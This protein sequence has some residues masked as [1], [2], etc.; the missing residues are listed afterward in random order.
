MGIHIITDSGSDILQGE[1][2]DITVLPM[3]ITFGEK[4]YLDGVNLSHQQ[5]YELLIEEEQL[6]VTSQVTP[7]QFE[8]AFRERVEAGDTVIAVV[9]SG[10]LSGTW[11]SACIAAREFP[12]KVYVVDSESAAI[13]ER[14]L[15]ERAVQLI[16]EGAQVEE[17]VE[18]LET[19]KKKIRLVALLDTLEY[20]KRGGRI[21]KSAA[22]VGGILSIK[23]VVAVENGEVCLLGKARGSRN[24]NNLLIQEIQ[25]TAG[26][27]FDRPYSLG[28]TGITDSLLQKY[29]ADSSV[30]WEEHADSLPIFS[31]GGTIGTHVG[32][33][34]IAVAFFTL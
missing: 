16:K 21:S 19:E 11:Q 25:K 30:I 13:G 26:I 3:A 14:I 20:L 4:E 8:N 18:K 7:I 29:I 24:G 6:P 17:I 2:P 22:M 10:K 34:A 32:P 33:G 31:I 23:P 28:Y 27:D 5:F 12:G 9:I 15:A 1:N